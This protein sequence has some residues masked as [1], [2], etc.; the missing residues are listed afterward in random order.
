MEVLVT[1]GAGF[2]GS[3]LVER[4]VKDGHN[5]C[6]ID[7]LHTGNEDNLRNVNGKIT[8][9][10]AR[11]GELV[12]FNKKFDVIFHQGAYSSSPMYKTNPLFLAE[13]VEDFLHILEYARKNGTRIVYASSSSVYNGVKPPHRE[14]AE[15]GVTDYYTE[16]RVVMERLA[17]LYN[18]LY[19]VN[20]VGLRYFSVYGPHEESKK[21]YAN[22]VTQFLWDAKKNAPLVVFGNGSQTRDFTYVDDIVEA[23][24]KAAYSNVQLGVYNAGTGRNYPI[25]QM[26]AMLGK[27]LGKELQVQ[28]IE[29]K[30][31][32]Y[33]SETLADTHKAEKEL[34]FK[35]TISLEE[36]INRLIKAYS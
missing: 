8:F 24:I 9:L 32:N 36:G 7:N 2:I 30:I 10:K 12:Q 5:V 35:A 26:I 31:K 3:N 4:L 6:V 22:L 20:S 29:N 14:D 21:Q 19:G 1:G 23:N 15:I 34:G 17:K 33:V 16:G 25:N 18:I 11:A 27:A 28:H 13:V